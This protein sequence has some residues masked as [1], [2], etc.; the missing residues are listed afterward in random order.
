MFSPPSY[1]GNRNGVGWALIGF[2]DEHV[3]LPPFGFYDRDYRG[4][5]ADPPRTP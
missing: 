3:F 4:L 1:G 5:V 2:A